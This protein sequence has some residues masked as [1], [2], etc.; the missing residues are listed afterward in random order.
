METSEATLVAMEEL[1]DEKRNQIEADNLL[2]L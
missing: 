2:V 1:T